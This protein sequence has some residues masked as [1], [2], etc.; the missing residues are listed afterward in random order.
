MA[1]TLALILSLIFKSQWHTLKALT[2]HSLAKEGFKARA[3]EQGLNSPINL[4][5]PCLQ[6]RSR[7][8]L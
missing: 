1:L 4:N 3:G 8:Q 5:S 6:F 7:N 2:T